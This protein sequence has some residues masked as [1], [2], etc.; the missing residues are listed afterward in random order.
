MAFGGIAVCWR[1]KASLRIWSQKW[2]CKLE[3]HF[4]DYVFFMCVY[5][6]VVIYSLYFPWFVLVF[7]LDVSMITSIL[8]AVANGV[9]QSWTVDLCHNRC[10]TGSKRLPSSGAI[11]AGLL[12]FGALS[13]NMRGQAELLA[14]GS[15]LAARTL[16]PQT[17]GICFCL[18]PKKS[19]NP[20]YKPK[21]T[22]CF[23]APSSHLSAKAGS[24]ASSTHQ[25]AAWR[26]AKALGLGDF[27]A[28]APE[29]CAP[30]DESFE[31]FPREDFW[32]S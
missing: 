7:F 24:L 11:L 29:S 2:S 27:S 3:E 1:E 16:D 15:W 28:M 6:S 5:I 18:T 32:C 23:K 26:D 10:H 21:N 20:L 19:M 9:G 22:R 13:I 8:A 30:S 17:F 25:V 4:R 31:D 14:V 12:L